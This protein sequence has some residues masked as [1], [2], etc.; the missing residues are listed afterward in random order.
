MVRA[1]EGLKPSQLASSRDPVI[2]SH[3][4]NYF[5]RQ[6]AGNVLDYP[7]VSSHWG[8]LVEKALINL[9]SLDFVGAQETFDAD[10]TYLIRRLNLPR[11]KK[12]SRQNV[13]PSGLEPIDVD[14]KLYE[15]DLKLYTQFMDQRK[16]HV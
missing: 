6:M 4:D 7:I 15:W 5:V 11:H 12:F 10:V 8:V 16:L 9:Q 3:A 14:P 13:S 2:L 1:C